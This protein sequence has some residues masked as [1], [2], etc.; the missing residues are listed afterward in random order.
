MNTLQNFRVLLKNITFDSLW[1]EVWEKQKRG[2]KA[3]L[4]YFET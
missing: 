3:L 4:N 2:H 1:Q